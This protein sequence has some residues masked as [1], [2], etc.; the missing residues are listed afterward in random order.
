MLKG[1]KIAGCLNS[2]FSPPLEK[3]LNKRGENVG[4]TAS[5]KIMLSQA[6]FVF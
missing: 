2:F 4:R 3:W 5:L 1:F 6:L